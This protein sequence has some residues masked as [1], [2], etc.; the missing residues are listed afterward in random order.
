MKFWIGNLGRTANVGVCFANLIVNK[1]SHGIHVFV[2]PI[3]DIKGEILPGIHLGDCG[4]K[5]GMNGIDNGG[6]LFRKVKVPYDS[7][8]DKFSWIDENG[9]FCSKEEN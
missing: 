7:L 4:P 9:N 8:L 1:K 3:R 2:V 6:V 5:M